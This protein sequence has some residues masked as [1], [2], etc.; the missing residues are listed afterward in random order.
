MA[1]ID[2]TGQRF[3]RLVVLGYA[4]TR[5]AGAYWHC[6]CDC[7]TEKTIHGGV[8]KAGSTRSCG[9]LLRE[10]A[11]TSR[12][13]K[14][15]G[16][17]FGRFLVLGFSHQ[18]KSGHSHWKCVCDCGTE[19][20]I[21]GS[22]LTEGDT[23]SCGCFHQEQLSKAR[24]THGH[25]RHVNG[26]Q[27]NSPTYRSWHSMMSRCH[28]PNVPSFSYYGGR[29]ITVCSQW[30]TFAGFLADMSVRPKFTSL[31]RINPDGNYEPD[32]CRWATSRE[33]ARNKQPLVAITFSDE[34]LLA[35]V[36]RR[37]LPI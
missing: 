14:I 28:N 7:G 18:D 2:L 1:R 27:H 37:G 26:K 15:A 5:N 10:T 23:V 34:E 35:E 36:R 17:R 30:Q 25:A 11:S 9:C 3:G 13:L 6:R 22:H 29:G 16:R 4:E 31:D 24:T 32:N 20:T 21:R 33:Q 19:K 8:M 12:I